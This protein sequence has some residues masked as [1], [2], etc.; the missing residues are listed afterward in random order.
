MSTLGILDFRNFKT[1]FSAN[2]SCDNDLN[3]A[4]L[5]AGYFDE[6]N[7]FH[8]L[9]HI[10]SKLKTIQLSN[11][12]FEN[13]DSNKILTDAKNCK[14]I[15]LSVYELTHG[16]AIL[17]KVNLE[18]SR[19]GKDNLP[20][21]G[22]ALENG[23]GIG[24][25]VPGFSNYFKQVIVLDFSL[26]YLILAKKIAQEQNLTN[27]IY[28]CANAEKLP[29]KDS[30]IDFI[31]SNNVV[32]HINDPLNMIKHA[33]RTLNNGALLYIQSPNKNSIY[34]EPHFNLP[35]YGF[36]PYKIRKFIILRTQNR[37]PNTVSLLTLSQ[38]KKL[39]K[40]SFNE[41]FQVTFIPRHLKSSISGGAIRKV[42]VGLLNTPILG[43]VINLLLNK[44]L[45]T[46]MPYHVALCFKKAK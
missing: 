33:E 19:L 3:L 10:Y 16:F 36:I 31:H 28:I 2:F 24:Y 27:I 18:L 35:C 4:K 38:L 15:G 14:Y 7:N 26:S 41:N 1:D 40:C 13:I 30:S 32:E 39:I 5:L 42:I 11:P 37:D 46:V 25:F 9:Y 22:I 21:S 34:I 20:T 29:I 12:H 23:C 43:I 17:D 6:T 44:L 45:L 8:E